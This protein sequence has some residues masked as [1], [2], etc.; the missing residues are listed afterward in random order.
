LFVGVCVGLASLT[1]RP[2]PVV[3]QTEPEPQVDPLTAELAALVDNRKPLS[4][5]PKAAAMLDASAAG[6]K[7]RDEAASLARTTDDDAPLLAAKLALE[8]ASLDELRRQSTGSRSTTE[9]SRAELVGPKP[10]ATDELTSAMNLL[11]L[12][13]LPRDVVF[14]EWRIVDDG[15]DV[16]HPPIPVGQPASPRPMSVLVRHTTPPPSFDL[17]IVGL[18]RAGSGPLLVSLPVTIGSS[19]GARADKLSTLSVAAGQ[20]TAQPQPGGFI[21]RFRPLPE[22]QLPPDVAPIPNNQVVKIVCRIRPLGVAV[23]V[24]GKPLGAGAFANTTIDRQF[25]H[26][27]DKL[28]RLGAFQ[29]MWRV[30]QMALTP[31]WDAEALPA[32]AIDLSQVEAMQRAIEPGF[33]PEGTRP[34]PPRPPDGQQPKSIRDILR[35]TLEGE[36]IE[37]GLPGIRP[38]GL[39]VPKGLF[40]K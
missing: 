13:Q 14:G 20:P 4:E 36:P 8:P 7:T 19:D 24:N 26:P 12:V 28:F 18:R 29:A 22:E 27:E 23:E 35:E 39:P 21:R 2:D 34:A 10:A 5:R 32:G 37:E 15:L 6:S 30:Q 17:T 1:R 3:A 33:I 40:P 9:W 16:S 25:R 11:L 38:K 31:V